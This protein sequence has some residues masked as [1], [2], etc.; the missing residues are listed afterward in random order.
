MNKTLKTDAVLT[1]SVLK[2]KQ[3]NK[4]DLSKMKENFKSKIIISIYLWKKL[5]KLCDFYHKR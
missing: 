2:I 3:D 5:E 4:Q 1:V